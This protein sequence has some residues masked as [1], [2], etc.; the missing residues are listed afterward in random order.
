MIVT[1]GVLGK[2]E[3]KKR[4]EIGGMART[5]FRAGE[6]VHLAAVW[7]MADGKTG[8][9][10]D[11]A[12]YIDGRRQPRTWEYPFALTGRDPYVLREVAPTIAIG[13]REGWL[14][15][16]RISRVA[17]YAGDF[18]PARLPLVPDADALALFRFDG[19]TEGLAG[20]DARPFAAE[21]QP[22]KP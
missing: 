18:A 10:G 12:I 11:F 8:T 19:T 15:E 16:L 9:T 5:F 3:E 7:A 20:A 13:C 17:R 14:D 1:R 22:G 6:W 4:D 21:L 2:P